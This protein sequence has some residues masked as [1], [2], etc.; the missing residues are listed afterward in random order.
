MAVASEFPCLRRIPWN[1]A[2]TQQFRGNGQIPRHGSKFRSPRKTVG[3]NYDII[4]H[5]SPP[6]PNFVTIINSYLY[7]SHYVKIWCHPQNGKYTTYCTVARGGLSHGHRFIQKWLLDDRYG[8]FNAIHKCDGQMVDGRQLP[9]YAWCIL[10]V[11]DSA[12][13]SL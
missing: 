5:C 2:E 8:H 4:M 9:C 3:L 6:Q 13:C 12:Q 10:N 11:V 7:M 1:S